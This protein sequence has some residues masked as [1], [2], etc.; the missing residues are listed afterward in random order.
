MHNASLTT[1]LSVINHYNAIPAVVT[2]PDTRL[3]QPGG[4]PQR[5]NLSNTQKADLEAFL[6]TLTGTSIYTDQKWSSPFSPAHTLSPAVLPTTAAT[7]TS[8]VNGQNIKVLTL[9]AK[10]VPHVA[11]VFQTST[12]LHAWADTPVTA[13]AL[14]VIDMSLPVAIGENQ[15]FYRFAYRPFTVVRQ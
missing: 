9:R 2:G 11:C 8:A 13:S 10:G 5:L 15:R 14:G 3:R 1:L 6:K 4:T 12:D 7:M